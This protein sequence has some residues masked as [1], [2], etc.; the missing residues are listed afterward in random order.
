MPRDSSGTEEGHSRTEKAVGDG[1]EGQRVGGIDRRTLLRTATAAAVGGAGA[2]AATGS[3]AAG[4][5]VD[6][7]CEEASAPS[8]FSRVST[9]DHF[10]G[11][12]NLTNGEDEWSYD[13]EGTWDSWGDDLVLFIHGWQSSDEDDDDIDGGYE[14][15]L[16]LE[17]EGWD[18][19]TAVY[20][21]DSDKGGGIDQGWGESKEIAQKNGRKLANFTQWYSRTY[22]ADVRWVCHSLGAEVVIYGLES[23]DNDYGY[24]NEVKS[25]SM[26]GGAIENDDVSTD[27]GWWDDEF[28]DHIEFATEQFDNFYAD[29]DEVLEWIFETWEFDGAVGSEGCEGPEPYNYTDHDVTSIVP[30]HY[31]Y[32]TRGCGCV[33]QVVNNW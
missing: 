9:R 18:G 8:D 27:A 16:A 26:L 23:I 33:T 14:T 7:D 4:N 22:G 24:W 17:Q 31:D 32:N 21:W 3:A 15:Q 13:V 20:T 28:G 2:S 29:D 11:D 1:D 19:E 6:G 25:V 30:T 10:D 12:A 5:L